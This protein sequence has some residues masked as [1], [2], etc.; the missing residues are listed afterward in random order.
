M[1]GG[2]CFPQSDPLS[3]SGLFLQFDPGSILPVPTLFLYAFPSGAQYSSIPINFSLTESFFSKAWGFPFHSGN[4]SRWRDPV[5]LPPHLAF[6]S[7]IR[8]FTPWY[9]GSSCV[10]L[11]V[12]WP[13]WVW[14]ESL[15]SVFISPWSHFI[16]KAH[17]FQSFLPHNIS[18]TNLC[19]FR[20]CIFNLF[21]S[22][23]YK[24]LYCYQTAFMTHFY[25]YLT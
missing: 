19:I 8:V 5:S 3:Q 16:S 17:R 1:K 6:S 25:H 14:C 2:L 22:A 13:H 4:F 15:P 21:L 20:T 10:S 9:F 23:D 24:E 11:P 18:W 7:A 12:K